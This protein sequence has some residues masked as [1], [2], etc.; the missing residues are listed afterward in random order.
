VCIIASL[1]ILNN[2]FSLNDLFMMLSGQWFQISLDAILV[3]FRKLAGKK[4]HDNT[5]QL[6]HPILDWICW[7]ISPANVSLVML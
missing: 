1:V 2:S 4:S 5:K 3:P 7:A 6:S